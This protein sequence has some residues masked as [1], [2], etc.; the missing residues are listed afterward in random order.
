VKN[1][2]LVD[3]DSLRIVETHDDEGCIELINEDHMSELLGLREE[4][5]VTPTHFCGF[6]SLTHFGRCSLFVLTHE[7]ICGWRLIYSCSFVSIY[8]Y[9]FIYHTHVKM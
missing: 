3:W 6:V 8:I 2:E 9:L 5:T 4:T 1:L 7:I